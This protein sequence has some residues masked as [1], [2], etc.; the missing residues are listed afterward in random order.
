MLIFS[1]SFKLFIKGLLV[2]FI[3]LNFQGTILANETYSDAMKWYEDNQSIVDP[4]KNYFIG[5]KLINEK[6]P[7][8]ALAFFRKAADS[9]LTEALIKVGLYLIKSDNSEEKKEAREIFKILSDNSNAIASF[10]LG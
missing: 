9:G 10:K 2:F 7:K 8:E 4:K 1:K 6:K 5:L 3:L